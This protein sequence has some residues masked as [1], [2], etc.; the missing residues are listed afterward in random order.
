MNRWPASRRSI[1]KILP[2][3]SAIAIAVAGLYPAA[4]QSPSAS[5]L[6]PPTL[7]PA[8]DGGVGGI[9]LPQ[10]APA[11]VPRGAAGLSVTVADVHVSTIFPEVKDGIDALVRQVR[12]KRLTVG[13]LY[14]L[15]AAIERLYAEAGY[16]LVRVVVPPQRLTDGGTFQL[17]VVD[18]YIEAVEVAA[19]PERVRCGRRQNPAAD[20]SAQHPSDGDRTSR[21]AGR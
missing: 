5:Q 17:T 10:S 4:A 6:T 1:G 3:A 14:A 21:A 2:A 16:V 7:R 9:A 12:G 18:G 11:E 19:V 8:P 20:R 13:A 15:A